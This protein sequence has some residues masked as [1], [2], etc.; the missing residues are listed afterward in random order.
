MEERTGKS[1]SCHLKDRA[2]VTLTGISEVVSFDENQVIVDTDLG[3]LI[4][5][6][7]DLHISR[8]TVEKGEADVEGQVDSLVYS[9]NDAYRKSGQS[10]LARLFK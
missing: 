1:H 4:L 8:L 9:S 2:A 3:L 7:R 5:K 10:L 6:G